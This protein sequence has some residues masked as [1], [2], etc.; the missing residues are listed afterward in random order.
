MA[1]RRFLALLVLAAGPLARGAEVV[2]NVSQG[3][4][5]TNLTSYITNN[6]NAIYNSATFD[7]VGTY[8]NVLEAIRERKPGY[9][10]MSV[11]EIGGLVGRT[12]EPTGEVNNGWS[13]NYDIATGKVTLNHINGIPGPSYDRWDS[14]DP[15]NDMMALTFNFGSLLDFNGNGAIDADERLVLGGR[16]VNGFI[17]YEGGS[18]VG[19][20]PPRVEFEWVKLA[21]GETRCGIVQEGA[22][23][24]LSVSGMLGGRSYVLERNE[25]LEDG[26]GWEEAASFVMPGVALPGERLSE[27][28]REP[29][30]PGGRRFYRLRWELP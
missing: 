14:N 1:M 17:G 13:S 7:L 26:M 22:E 10:G 3:S 30:V 23:V 5:L 16:E 28:W 11:N 21:L 12:I 4:G 25:D 15:N 9:A 19:G 24:V 27:E 20:S 2:T 18:G 8:G 29:R 6:D